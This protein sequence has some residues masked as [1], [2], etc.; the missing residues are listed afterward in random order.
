MQTWPGSDDR[1]RPRDDVQ[2]RRL[3]LGRSFETP[4]Q[5]LRLSARV[6]LGSGVHIRR[7]GGRNSLLAVWTTF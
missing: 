4:L 6:P 7:W 3:T 2:S 1:L 5:S